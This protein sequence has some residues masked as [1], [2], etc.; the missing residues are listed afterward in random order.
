MT[1]PAEV[2]TAL[3]GRPEVGA[4]D[5]MFPLLTVDTTGFPHVCLLGRAELSTDAD[6][7]YAVLAS[8]TTVGNLKRTGL[9]TLIVIGATAAAY[10]KLTAGPG[11]LER[12]GLHGFEFTLAEVK[13][14]SAA[15]DLTPPRFQVDARLTESERWQDS[16]ALLAELAGNHTIH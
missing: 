4:W 1:V 14:D 15:V 11:Q 10:C 6:H 2:R 13:F 12:D 3:A 7:V 8:P 9:A 5:P 16:A